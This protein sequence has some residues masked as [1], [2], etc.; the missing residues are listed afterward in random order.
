MRGRQ[1]DYGGHE[2]LVVNRETAH[3]RLVVEV[4]SRLPRP[5]RG[6]FARLAADYRAGHVMRE[7]SVVE[8]EQLGAAARGLALETGRRLCEAGLVDDPWQVVYLRMDELE[9]WLHG[10]MLMPSGSCVPEWG[11]G[12]G[13]MRS[14][15]SSEQSS[16]AAR[17]R[18]W[19]RRVPC[20]SA[21]PPA[22]GQPWARPGWSPGRQALH[23]CGL[24]TSWCAR[25][26][27]R[28]GP[29]CSLAPPQWLP[30]AAEGSP[31]PLPWLA[32]TPSRLC[33]GSRE[34]PP[35]SPRA[36]TSP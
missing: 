8:F 2:D 27:T 18:F 5:L 10:E 4:S 12:P 34:P 17:V 9:A 16:A 36:P 14:G 25:P 7:A 29:R 32:S 11:P 20:W 24:A 35:G 28:R 13:P 21:W 3:D 22:P 6:R 30:R 31:T 33:S 1:E 23:I 19:R 26:P 15:T